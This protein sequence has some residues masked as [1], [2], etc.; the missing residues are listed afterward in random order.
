MTPTVDL[1]F[2]FKIPQSMAKLLLLLL[3]NKSLT[4][5]EIS[6][7]H[8]ISTDGRTAAHRLRRYLK[9]YNIEIKSRREI[10]YW[11]EP[12]TKDMIK[13]LA[14]TGQMTL[15]LDHGGSPEV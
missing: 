13:K 10:G 1:Q 6:Q 15:P 5:Q 3:N 4:T 9:D 11:L 12:E 14:D 2:A 7:V 8:K